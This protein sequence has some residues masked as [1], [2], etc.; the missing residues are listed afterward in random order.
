MIQNKHSATILQSVL[1]YNQIT[2]SELCKI[3]DISAGALVKY[4]RPLLDTG[5]L[6]ETSQQKANGAGRRAVYLEFNPERGVIIAITLSRSRLQSAILTTTGQI[7]EMKTVPYD[8]NSTQET[9]IKM[10]E[11][12]V[13]QTLFVA[14]ERG[15]SP[16]GIGISMGGQLD[17]KAGISS[18]YLF[19]KNWF[20]VPLQRIIE[21]LTS[22]PTFLVKD[23]NAC[24]LGEQFFGNGIGV[25][26]FLSVWLGTG[27][28][29][30]IVIGGENYVGSDGYAGEIGH[31]RGGDPSKLCY[32]GRLGCV[33]TSTGKDYVLHKCREGLEVGVMSSMKRYCN[34][35]IA[36]L[37]LEHVIRA[38][39]DGD[40]LAGGVF[41]EVG[42]RIGLTLC[43]VA[44]IFNPRMII[45]RG[46]LIDGNRHLFEV[47]KRTVLDHSLKKIANKLEILYAQKDEG[48]QFKGLCSVVLDGLI[49]EI[50]TMGERAF[51]VR[52][53]RQ[54]E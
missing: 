5:I 37:T 41:T 18:E 4:I 53:S 47:I 12:L 32:C 44:N 49:G 50:E 46:P 1:K 38:A 35:D 11:S 30:G 19:A 34:D 25:D 22:I 9:L 27:I 17:A 2:R 20:N 8:E 51:L 52:E 43:D 42:E 36:S 45:L 3:L 39:D 13:E 6:R 54:E 40:R 48:I 23:T 10:I 14:H 31:T 28:G 21:E 33:E 24:V 15:Q 26:N 29:M 7:T 16:I